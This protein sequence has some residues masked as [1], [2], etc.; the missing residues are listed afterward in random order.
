MENELKTFRLPI[1]AEPSLIVLIDDWRKKQRDLPSR[2]E[3]VRRLIKLGLSHKEKQET[4]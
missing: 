3:A 4:L 1:Q 2:S